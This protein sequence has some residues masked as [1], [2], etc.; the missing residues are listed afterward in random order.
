MTRSIRGRRDSAALG[1]ARQK[2]E[3]LGDRNG[4][5]EPDED[6]MASNG[7]A[8]LRG[9]Q[10]DA[11]AEEPDGQCGVGMEE[12]A[13]AESRHSGRQLAELRTHVGEID[14]LGD[15][16]ARGGDDAEDRPDSC[17]RRRECR[18]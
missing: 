2:D 16:D 6:R 10:A 12:D 14:R 11:V 15:E 4:E 3:A 1:I 5:D 18:R 13:G 9:G 17:L 8:L 7:L